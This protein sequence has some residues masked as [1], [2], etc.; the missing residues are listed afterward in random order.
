MPF[1]SRFVFP[2]RGHTLVPLIFRGS[3][4]LMAMTLNTRAGRRPGHRY[5]ARYI[6]VISYALATGR[7]RF[8]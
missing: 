3:H 4:V 1:F 5:V 2:L 6:R 8:V 7:M